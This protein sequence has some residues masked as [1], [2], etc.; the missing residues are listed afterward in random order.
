[1]AW[2]AGRASEVFWGVFF[3][4]HPV[5]E[6]SED[7]NLFW[8]QRVTGVS[9]LQLLFLGLSLVI[10]LGDKRMLPA[11]SEGYSLSPQSSRGATSK[12]MGSRDHACGGEFDWRFCS[13]LA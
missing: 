2:T 1:M 9:S 7:D 4:A 13:D 11:C 8:K 6:S 5:G 3:A 12:T 10:F